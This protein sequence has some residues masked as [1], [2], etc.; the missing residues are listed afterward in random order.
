MELEIDES[1]FDEYII[2]WNFRVAIRYFL[3]IP[4]R[5]ISDIYIF[6]WRLREV[7]GEGSIETLEIVANTILRLI[8][9]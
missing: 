1:Y 2:T 3:N 9:V 4:K 7:I 6:T 5:S 8:H